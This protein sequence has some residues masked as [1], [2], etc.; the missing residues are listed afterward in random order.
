MPIQIVVGG[1][2]EGSGAFW[3]LAATHKVPSGGAGADAYE[4]A[5]LFAELIR[6]PINT[7]IK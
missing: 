3:A 1:H 2:A 4:D 7:W 5:I 6:S